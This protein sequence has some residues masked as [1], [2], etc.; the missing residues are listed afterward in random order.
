VGTGASGLVKILGEVKE[1]LEE[2]GIELIEE[3]TK[4]ACEIYNKLS[5]QK[6][7]VA[8]FHLTC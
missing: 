3:Q 2:E 1:K 6:R 7:V 8:V 4:K 5:P